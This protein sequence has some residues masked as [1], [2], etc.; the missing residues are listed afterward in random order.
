MMFWGSMGRK[1]VGNLVPIEGKMDSVAYLRIPQENM[2]D[3]AE[4]LGLGS[5]FIFQQDNDPKHTS[6]L[7][8][9]FFAENDYELLDCP[10]Q[11]PDLNPIEHL[12]SYIKKRYHVNPSFNKREMLIKIQEIWAEITQDVTANLVDSVYRRFKAVIRAKGGA[13]KY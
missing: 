1:G 6:A 11:S 12:W 8:K 7:V 10:A 9:R 5:G 3:S 2:L 13:T 4:K